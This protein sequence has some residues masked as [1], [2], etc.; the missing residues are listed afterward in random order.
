M[1]VPD[2]ACS[3]PGL[4][5]D[6]AEVP[7]L[8]KPKH[9]T[10]IIPTDKWPSVSRFLSHCV[11]AFVSLELLMLASLPDLS[12]PRVVPNHNWRANSRISPE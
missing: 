1:G 2:S 4:H 11:L 7:G 9:T 8:S 3:S 12:S 10:R 5:I 6:L